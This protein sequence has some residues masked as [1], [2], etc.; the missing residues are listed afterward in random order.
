MEKAIGKGQVSGETV[1]K[2]T[3]EPSQLR[4]ALLFN[5]RFGFC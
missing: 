5:R 3:E 4:E 1:D 2:I